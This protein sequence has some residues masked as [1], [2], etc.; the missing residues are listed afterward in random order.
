MQSLSDSKYPKYLQESNW[1]FFQL[2]WTALCGLCKK[3]F[4]YALSLAVH[5]LYKDVVEL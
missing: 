4:Y 5:H 2:C 1:V 3:M